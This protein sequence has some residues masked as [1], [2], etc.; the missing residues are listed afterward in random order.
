MF[1]FEKLFHQYILIIR[2]YSSE[3]FA[4]FQ[5]SLKVACKIPLYV[6]S[7]LLSNIW[8]AIDMCHIYFEIGMFQKLSLSF[9]VCQKI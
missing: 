9:C 6:T 5:K 7:K 3:S 1:T 4:L 2:S 8:Q